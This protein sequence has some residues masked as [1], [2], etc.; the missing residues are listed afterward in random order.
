[1]GGFSLGFVL[2]GFSRLAPGAVPVAEAASPAAT[3]VNAWIQIG[4]DGSVTVTVGC[5]EL[6]Q[7]SLSSLPQIVAEELMVDYTKVTALQAGADLAYITGGSSSVRSHYLPLRQAGAAA[8][9]MLVQAAMNQVGDQTR[10]NY[11]VTS[12]VVTYTPKALTFPYG[13]LAPAAALLPAPANP[14]LTPDS[15]F[16]LIGQSLP[17]L[18]IP[19]KTD[20]SAIYGLDVRVP[21]MVYAVIKHCPAFGGTLAQIPSTPAGALKGCRPR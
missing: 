1:M 9:E 5:A 2:P 4:S 7:G 17:R 15:Q 14:P 18:D 16:K 21:G 8:R 12:G 19:S 11:T 10:A 3:Q 6:G 20:G 13:Q